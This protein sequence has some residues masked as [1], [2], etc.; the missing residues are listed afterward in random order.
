MIVKSTNYRLYESGMSAEGAGSFLGMKSSGPG[1]GMSLV[2]RQL[3]VPA[4]LDPACLLMSCPICL[5]HL[6]S[7]SVSSFS[8]IVFKIV[9]KGL[10]W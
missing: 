3:T 4:P 7:Y 8:F 1:I 10:P 9:F 6:L 5:V 2:R